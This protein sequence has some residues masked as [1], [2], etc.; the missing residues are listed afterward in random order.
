MK[1]FVLVVLL[2]ILGVSIAL[3][4]WQ[5]SHP[6]HSLKCEPKKEVWVDTIPFFKPVPKDSIVLRY[7]TEKLPVNRDKGVSLVDTALLADVAGDSV[8]VDIPI[9][10]KVY[11]DSL[12]R[13][14]VSGYHASLDSIFVNRYTEKI[15]IPPPAVK[16][17]R[18]GIGVQ[19]GYGY[20]P[21]RL[22]PYVGIGVSYN[23]FNF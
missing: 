4:V 12:Y 3:N 16:Q 13:A 20:T 10:Q 15:Y 6:F 19:V 2:A 21:G 11:E 22:Q 14:Y 7:I 1:K 5:Y 9:T 23:I 18:F 17:K 8:W